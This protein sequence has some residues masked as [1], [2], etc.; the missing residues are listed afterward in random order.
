MQDVVKK[1]GGLVVL[2]DAFESQMFKG[3]FQKIFTRDEKGTFPMAFNATLE[4]QVL[5]FFLMKNLL[6]FRLQEI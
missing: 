6:L 1:S 4:V 5:K 3:S 2:A